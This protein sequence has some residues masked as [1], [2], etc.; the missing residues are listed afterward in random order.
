L[1][2][3]TFGINERINVPLPVIEMPFPGWCLRALRSSRM[4]SLSRFVFCHSTDVKVV[5]TTSLGVRLI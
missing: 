3:E 2:D 5:E 4:P 1:I